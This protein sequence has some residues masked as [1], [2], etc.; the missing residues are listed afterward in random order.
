GAP[1]DDLSAGGPAGQVRYAPALDRTA[2]PDAP[3]VAARWRLRRPATA[4]PLCRGEHRAGQRALVLQRACGARG[5]GLLRRARAAAARGGRRPALLRCRPDRPPGRDRPDPAGP[6]SGRKAAMLPPRL[7]RR[8]LLAP[9]VIVIAVA[10]VV[11]FPL[12]ALVVLAFGAVGRS[13]PGRMRILRLLY[14]A[15]IW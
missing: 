4:V 10:L 9:L 15:L 12:L 3:G 7:I 5:A 11:L 2:A 6:A 13:R 14:F 8:L 1:R